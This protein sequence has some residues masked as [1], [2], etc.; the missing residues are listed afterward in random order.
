MSRVASANA[1][2]NLKAWMQTRH[3][4]AP[5]ALRQ[6]MLTLASPFEGAPGG[7]AGQCLV[8][9]Q[10]GLAMLLSGDGTARAAALDLL[11]ID[12]LVTYGFEACAGEPERIPE[13]AA[14]VMV[15][16]SALA[17]RA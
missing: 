8:A 15:R 16:L 17:P 2:G 6:R 1:A 3:P 4:S 9:A 7:V 5:T 14:D 11:A 12:A 13:L 10:Q